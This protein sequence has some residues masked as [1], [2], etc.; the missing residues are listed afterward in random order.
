MNY[1]DALDR[2]LSLGNNPGALEAYLRTVPAWRSEI[3]RAIAVSRSVAR[4]LESVTPD[5]AAARRSQQH[6]MSAVSRLAT[7]EAATSRSWASGL[8][9]GFALHRFAVAGVVAAAML[10]LVVVLN[11]PSISGGGTQTAEAV[12]IEG[13][14]AEVSPNAMTVSVNNAPQTVKISSDT[15]LQDGFGNTVEASKLSAGQDVVLEGSRSGDDFLATQVQLRDLLFGVVTSLPGDGIHLSSAS[16]DYVIQVTAE[17]QFEGVIR[18]GDN[19]QVKLTRMSDGGLVAVEVEN[20]GGDSED[21]QQGGDGE[22]ESSGSPPASPVPA[23]T[24]SGSSEGGTQQSKE[25]DGST[26]QSEGSASPSDSSHEG[27][28]SSHESEHGDD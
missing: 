1:Q 19:I 21:E 8:I 23:V 3:E 27:S 28:G 20:E 16:G 22:H 14:L 25:D 10:L 2:A 12:V 5:H 26:Q 15:V 17:T 13:N 11:L 6:L 9:S 18:V 7:A 24:Q 4:Q